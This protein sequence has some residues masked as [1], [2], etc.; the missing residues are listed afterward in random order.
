M[1]TLKAGA[2]QSVITP[3][4]AGHRIYLAGFGHNRIATGVHDELYARCLALNVRTRTLVLCSADLIGLFY[5]DVVTVRQAFQA[6]APGTFLIIACTHTHAGPDTLGLYGPTPLQTGS[7]R[8]YLKWVDERIASTAADAVRS[9]QP[10]RL[11]LARDDHPLL[12]L[13]QGADRPPLVKDPFLFVMRLVARSSGR[14]IATVINWSDHPEVL[15]RKNTQ[16]TSDYPHWVRSYLEKRFGG[17]ALFFSGSIG[18]LSPLGDQVALLDP[19]TGKIAEDGTWRK[20]ELLGTEVGRLAERALKSAQQV[21]PDSLVIRSATIFAPM[22]N[23]HFRLAESVGL[24]A[25][26]KPLYTD[27]RLDPAT[28]EREVPDVGRVKYPTGRDIQ[29]EVDYIQLR[30]RGRAVAEIVTVPGEIYPELVNGGAARYSGADYPQAPFE[31]VLREQ[32]HS[33]YQF[34]FGLSNDEIGYLI[35]KA[36][37][38]EEPPWLMNAVKPWYGEINS[39]GPEAAGVV[40]R[41]LATLIRP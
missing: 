2:A 22:H 36:E 18:K 35:P 1:D 34:I 14:T 37:W 23:A 12:G 29:T 8:K 4:L 10:A 28:E 15:G 40:L 19:E 20:A 9:M 3:E 33:R 13:L 27:G 30:A 7:D 26:R 6:K 32:L 11:E 16:I 24:F 38:D 39:V 31:P 41:A 17:V 21:N 25:G 5:D